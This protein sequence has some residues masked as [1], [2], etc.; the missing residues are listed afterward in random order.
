MKEGLH[1]TR[2]NRRASSIKRKA[3]LR[4]KV[5]LRDGGVC[6]QCKRDTEKLINDQRNETGQSRSDAIAAICWDWG[7]NSNMGSN[8]R[9]TFRNTL[10]IADHIVP[11]S[12][13][14]RDTLG[15]LQTLC[16]ECNLT[17]S[18]KD[19]GDAMRQRHKA[20]RIVGK[21]GAR[22]M[23]MRKMR[24]EQFIQESDREMREAD[25]AG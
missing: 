3:G 1:G 16:L 4:D 5:K 25:D 19:I 24:E 8:S 10:W 15:N 11:L 18:I 20:R 12:L 17:K 22:G 13:G 14:G 6:A 2:S 7:V 23:H 9:Q 21:L